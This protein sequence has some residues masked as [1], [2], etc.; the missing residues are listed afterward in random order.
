MTFLLTVAA[1]IGLVEWF[2]PFCDECNKR[3]RRG[4]DCW[5]CAK[6]RVE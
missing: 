1:I 2:Y 3:Y 4:S 5:S 6:I